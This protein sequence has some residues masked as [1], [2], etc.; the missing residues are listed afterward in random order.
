VQFFQVCHFQSTPKS[1]MEQC[2]HVLDKTSL[3][4]HTCYSLI[5]KQQMPQMTLPYVAE[6]QASSSNVILW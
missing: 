2:T 6:L 1:Q 5:Q 3:S 4:N